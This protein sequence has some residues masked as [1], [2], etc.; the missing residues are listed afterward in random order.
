M[1]KLFIEPHKL[2]IEPHLLNKDKSQLSFSSHNQQ[3]FIETNFETQRNFIQT[4]SV[5]DKSR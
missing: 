4:N 1:R 5:F 2:F 3:N